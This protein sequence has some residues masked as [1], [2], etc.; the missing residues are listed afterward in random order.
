[1][2][3]VWSQSTKN[4]ERLVTI[5]EGAL[6]VAKGREAKKD[7][8]IFI[9]EIRIE[10]YKSVIVDYKRQVETLNNKIKL[11]NERCDLVSSKTNSQ[12]IILLSD[13]RKLKKEKRFWK[14]LSI[15][16]P[17]VAVVVT[18]AVHAKL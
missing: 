5:S 18:T 16:L 6:S 2:S 11:D 13:N 4:S 12:N 10:H 7:S 1:M 15:V 3:K 17:V 8:I 14:G 9:Q